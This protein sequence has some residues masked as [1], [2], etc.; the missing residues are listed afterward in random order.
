MNYLLSASLAMAIFYALYGLLFR[1]LPFH[2]LN[3]AYLLAALG[4]SLLIPLVELPAPAAPLT[5]PV[6]TGFYV[7]DPEPF[8]ETVFIA[9]TEPKLVDWWAVAWYAYLAGVGGMA[10]RLGRSLWQL[11]C[12]LARPGERIDGLTIIPTSGQN[13]SFFHWILLNDTDLD[14]AERRQVLAHEAEHTRLG[15]SADRLLLEALRVV[16]WFNPVLWLVQRSL[17]HLHELEVDARMARRFEAQGYARLLLKLHGGLA[18]PLTNLFSQQPLRNRIRALF[19]PKPTNAMKKLLYLSALPLLAAVTL[20]LAQQAPP[21]P[22]PPPPPPSAPPPP[23]PP[24]A[25]PKFSESVGE[26]IFGD[27][28]QKSIS[29]FLNSEKFKP[30]FITSNQSLFEKIGFKA[31]VLGKAVTTKNKFE[32]V[33]FQLTRKSDGKTARAFFSPEEL[34]KTRRHVTLY[35][36]GK[37]GEFYVRSGPEPK[38][39]RIAPKLRRGERQGAITRPGVWKPYFKAGWVLEENGVRLIKTNEAELYSFDVKNQRINS[40]TLARYK[41]ELAKLG[42]EVRFLTLKLDGAKRPE[43]MSAS[44]MDLKTGKSVRKTIELTKQWISKNGKQ[45][46]VIGVSFRVDE[47]GNPSINPRFDAPWS[48]E[49]NVKKTRIQSAS[50]VQPGALVSSEGE[51]MVSTTQSEPTKPTGLSTPIQTVPGRTISEAVG[52]GSYPL[53]FINGSEHLPDVLLRLDPEKM[54]GTRTYPPNSPAALKRW[55]ERAT[56]GAI[57]FSPPT[58]GYFLEDEGKR[59]IAAYNARQEYD[60]LNQAPVTQVVIWF[61][62]RS[63]EGKPYEK[64]VCRSAGSRCGTEVMAG[65]K[66]AFV[67]NGKRVSEAEMNAAGRRKGGGCGAGSPQTLYPQLAKGTDHVIYVNG[68]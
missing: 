62:Q 36:N 63:Y 66:I 68:E 29:L 17:A 43:V 58:N 8:P 14:E 21:P 7:E 35:A 26:V 10:L 18:L 9:P 3:R 57:E 51:R 50:D 45:M 61:P 2:A 49:R 40:V 20:S 24:P 54:G 30:D 44:M 52:L 19:Q 11:R 64:V 47:R 48:R 41:S 6:Q 23:P 1:R 5:L 31:E 67:L 59:R 16:F 37:T 39:D 60:A 53:V 33:G 13:A 38:Y 34:K 22:P 56:D 65:E 32:S 46:E 12:L 15:H 27:E 55:G 4:V 42:Y 25:P 28:H